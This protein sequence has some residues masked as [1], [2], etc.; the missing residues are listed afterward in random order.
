MTNTY[1][2]ETTLT[3]AQIATGPLAVANPNHPIPAGL[4]FKVERRPSETRNS[5]N[6]NGGYV[7]PA[8]ISLNK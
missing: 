2:P 5:A 1:R 7:S 4:R 8:D 6:P 3:P